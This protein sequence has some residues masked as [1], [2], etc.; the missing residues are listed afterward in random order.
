MVNIKKP[1]TMLKRGA[2]KANLDKEN[3]CDDND[4]NQVMDENCDQVRLKINK[5]IDSEEVDVK[6]FISAIHVSLVSYN[7]FMMQHGKDKGSRSE[8]YTNALRYFKER[9]TRGISMS[10]KSKTGNPKLAGGKAPGSTKQAT[11]VT[12]TPES[13]SSPTA[14]NMHLKSAEDD[15]GSEEDSDLGSDQT[16]DLA[17]EENDSIAI[18]DSCDEIRRKINEHLRKPGVTQAQFLRDLYAQFHGP[19]KPR[20]LQ[21]VQLTTFRNQ[22]GAMTGNT[23]GIYY[24]AYVFFE[25]ERLAAQLPKSE[26]RL[27]MEDAWFLESG[28]DVSKILSG[29]TYIAP[30]GSSIYMNDLGKIGSF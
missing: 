28:V 20:S 17:G 5:L 1:N 13:T 30:V 6:D 8:T 29:Q 18:Y 24:A 9:E 12:V 22:I 27:D 14:V 10:K 2:E 19:R 11:T 7:R 21:G 23:S 16:D 25:K 4:D 26:H 15:L 3:V